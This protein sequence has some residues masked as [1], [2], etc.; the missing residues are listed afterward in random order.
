MRGKRAV[1]DST[2]PI[3]VDPSAYFDTVNF[4]PTSM[5]VGVREANHRADSRAL[6]CHRTLSISHG[7]TAPP[8][9]LSFVL[10]LKQLPLIANAMRRWPFICMYAPNLL[11]FV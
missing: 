6:G 2:T 7:V 5:T 9:L 1:L 8:A 4:S 10:H 3:H 11:R